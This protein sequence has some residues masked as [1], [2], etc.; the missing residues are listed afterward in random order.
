MF[1]NDAPN[2]DHGCKRGVNGLRKH[3]RLARSIPDVMQVLQNAKP[4]MFF[5]IE[6]PT[7]HY[8][9]DSELLIM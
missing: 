2:S 9:Q 3:L 5:N 8:R 1:D 6:N 4:L 7:G